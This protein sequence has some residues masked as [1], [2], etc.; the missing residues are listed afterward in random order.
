MERYFLIDEDAETVT[1]LDQV[2]DVSYEEAQKYFD[3]KGWIVGTVKS[4]ID[5]NEELHNE[6][7]LYALEN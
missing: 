7:E 5:W 1:I 6:S 4:E 3:C 2:F